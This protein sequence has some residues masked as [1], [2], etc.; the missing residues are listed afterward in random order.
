[1]ARLRPPRA[2]TTITT[3]LM[4]EKKT[5]SWDDLIKEI[6]AAPAPDALERKRPAIE[7]TFTPPP[8]VAAP[9]KPKA[10]N[11]GGLASELGIEVP[12]EPTPPPKPKAEAKAKPEPKPKPEPKVKA[13]AKSKSEP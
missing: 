8:V 12:P 11:W 2:V 10:S 13:E 4:D 9:P 3:Y 5:S 7:T 6:G 1:M